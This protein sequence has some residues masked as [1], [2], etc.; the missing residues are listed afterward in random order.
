MW[1]LGSMKEQDMLGEEKLV[2]WLHVNGEGWGTPSLRM[3]WGQHRLTSLRG[4][5]QAE[6]SNVVER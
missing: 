1:S 5:F 6:G 2:G 4:S 3:R